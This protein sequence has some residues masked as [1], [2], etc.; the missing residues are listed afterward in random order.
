LQ[1]GS[2]RSKLYF[3]VL[4]YM[5]MHTPARQQV[6]DLFD[7][8][9][10]AI[11]GARNLA[12]PITRASIAMAESLDGGGKILICGNGGSAADSLHFS[13]ELLNK[14]YL[15]RRPLAAISLVADTSTLTSIANDDSFDAV[16]SRQIEALGKPGD[17]LVPIT[18]SGN[19]PSILRAVEA[20]R[21]LN[22]Q[23]I[24]LNG[25]CGGKLSSL[26]H[27]NDIDIIV[28]QEKT[29]R[30][31]EVHGIIIHAFCQFI[32]QQLFGEN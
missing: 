10:G 20:A 17:I 8:S 22:I 27:D 2:G 15:V 19:S 18:S 23:V 9:I 1:Y 24:A 3:L 14:F 7:E 30:I 29:A 25:Q 21:R 32:D 16:F 6:N 12:G 28:P 26:L 11:E 5:H 4:L 31:Q 13:S